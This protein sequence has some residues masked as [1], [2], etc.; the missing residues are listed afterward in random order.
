M[1]NA[2]K[3]DLEDKDLGEKC[4]RTSRMVDSDYLDDVRDRHIYTHSY[5][6]GLL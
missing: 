4:T 5:L 2:E 6:H 1:D 3:N